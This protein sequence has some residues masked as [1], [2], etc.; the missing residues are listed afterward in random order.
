M[1]RAK[2]KLRFLRDTKHAIVLQKYARR[3]LAISK[4]KFLKQTKCAIMI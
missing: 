4:R 3:K 1:Y 2:K